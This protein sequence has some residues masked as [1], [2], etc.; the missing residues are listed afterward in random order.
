MAVSARPSKALEAVA[1][2]LAASGRMAYP[3]P[4][5]LLNAEQTTALPDQAADPIDQAA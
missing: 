3:L 1:D 2:E 5:D 4:A